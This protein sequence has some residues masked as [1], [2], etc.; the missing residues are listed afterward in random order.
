[1]TDMFIAGVCLHRLKNSNFKASKSI[2]ILAYMTS[3]T[4]EISQYYFELHTKAFCNK[5][6]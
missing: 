4:S 3:E 5:K 2:T 1:M 6:T